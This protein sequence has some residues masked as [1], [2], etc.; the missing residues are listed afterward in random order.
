METIIEQ[1]NISIDKYRINPLEEVTESPTYCLINNMPALTAGNFSLIKGK[2]K[3]GKTFLLNAIIASVINNSL[4]LD[5][6]KGCLPD[7]KGN[8]LYFDTEQ[9]PFHANRTVKRTC[10]LTDDPNPHNLIAYRLRPLLAKDRLEKIK[11]IIIKT[12]NVGIVAID[13]IRDLL[14][15]GINNEQEATELTSS[16][17]T[18][19]DELNLH[20]I[21]LLHQNKNDSNARG[22]I[23]TEI[24]NKAETIITVTKEG[25]N[26]LFNVV[27][28][29]SRDK[30][31]DDF[32]F[33]IN[34]EGLPISAEISIKKNKKITNPV[35]ITDDKH[36]VFLDRIFADNSKV[37]CT[38]F[39]DD[40]SYTFAV[41]DKP[42]REFISYY[43][44][45]GWI[46][47]TQNGNNKYYEYM[48]NGD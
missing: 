26:N 39:K 25:K 18:W 15:S 38:S 14:T 12:P 33:S 47:R 4:Q 45:K 1:N 17:L 23:G 42:S 34:E 11:N 9:S 43:T 13:G 10:K 3:A 7:D 37:S 40:I 35:N 29:D 32:A 24:V 2:K 30:S 20:I 46:K 44:S 31:F 28:E 41:S 5:S 36:F 22:H 6:I 16:L 27:C 48:L 8:V 19:T 21:L